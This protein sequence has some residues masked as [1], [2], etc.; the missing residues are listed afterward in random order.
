MSLSREESDVGVAA[1]LLCSNGRAT[2]MV[3][4]RW[5][6]TWPCKAQTMVMGSNSQ[7]ASLPFATY[8]PMFLK[9]NS[10]VILY[11]KGSPSKGCVEHNFYG[12]HVEKHMRRVRQ[13]HVEFLSCLRCEIIFVFTVTFSLHI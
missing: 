1:L 6:V 8:L 13:D 5:H 4:A 3:A 2:V 11:K 12:A 10:Y 9:I 7:P